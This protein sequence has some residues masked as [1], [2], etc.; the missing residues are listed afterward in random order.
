MVTEPIS[1]PAHAPSIVADELIVKTQL[2]PFTVL[3]SNRESIRPPN[4]PAMEEDDVEFV[5][6]SAV[7]VTFTVEF[8][9][10]AILLVVAG[11]DVPA[12]NPALQKR[13]VMDI[14]SISTPLRRFNVIELICERALF[15]TIPPIYTAPTPILLLCSVTLPL[16]VPVQNEAD[17]PAF[18]AASCTYPNS[19]PV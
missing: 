16:K 17:V 18:V 13:F 8:I 11:P 9:I 5:S 1:P 15:A 4:P 2:L 7:P 10:S 19:I 12:I 14:L 3:F 6:I